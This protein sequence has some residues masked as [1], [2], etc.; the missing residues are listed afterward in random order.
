ML[1]L[2][3]SGKELDL[4]NLREKDI[5]IIDIAHALSNECRFGGHCIRFYSVAQHSITCM[6]MAKIAN[7]N[8]D[9]QLTALMHDATEA[10]IKDLPRPIKALIPEYNN[11]EKIIWET[12]AKKYS[13][14]NIL[15]KEVTDI[16]DYLLRYELVYLM[17]QPQPKDALDLMDIPP[18]IPWGI[19]KHSFLEHF[20]RLI[21]ERLK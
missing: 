2:V 16:D 1:Q 18:P 7:L 11:M 14:P 12:I 13:L 10:Y 21:E 5:D 6:K 4:L 15:P 20:N 9:Y 8:I 3:Y 19:A 17:N